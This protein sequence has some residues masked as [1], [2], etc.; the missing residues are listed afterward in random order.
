ME[1]ASALQRRQNIFKETL[2]GS[3]FRILGGG[4]YFAFVRVPHNLT[5]AFSGIEFCEAIARSRG[6]VLLPAQFFLPSDSSSVLINELSCW[7]RVSVANVD[8]DDIR[9]VARRLIAFAEDHRTR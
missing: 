6:V 8:D 2:A 4:G 9:E 5:P 1:T 7:V 3:D